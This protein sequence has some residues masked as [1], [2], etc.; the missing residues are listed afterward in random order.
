MGCIKSFVYLDEYKMYSISSQ[1]FEG[2]TEY[3]LSGKKSEYAKSEEQKGKIL[4]GNLMGEILVKEQSSTE[5][6][7]LH[8]YA[9]NLFE[10][11]LS[12]MGVLYT[13]PQNVT[14]NDL[15][16]KSF[17]KISGKIIFNDYSKMASTLEQFNEI[18]EAIGYFKYR[19]E[20]E[21][22]AELAKLPKKIADRNSKAKATS[23]LNVLKFSYDE[24][25]EVT[26]PF[27]NKEIIFSSILNRI[28]LREKEDILISKYSRKTEFEF[29]VLGIV[30][31][32]GNENIEMFDEEEVVDGFRSAIQNTI[33]KMAG[34]ETFFTGRQSSECRIEPI[35]I[36]RE[37]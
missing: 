9:Y 6:K 36:Y 16:D 1:L 5:K 30:T 13:V 35:A 23:L 8:D 19:E 7:Y 24:Q 12:E 33:D 3:V 22:V 2:L 11:K 18:G 17:V 20:N 34:V 21:S 14:L 26:M 25:F 37:L 10:N 15:R 31:Q 4:S 29:T 32:A 28:Y 27:A